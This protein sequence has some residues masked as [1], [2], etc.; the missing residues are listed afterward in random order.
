MNIM[1]KR[2]K[3]RMGSC[4]CSN[5]GVEF[6]KALSELKRNEKLGRKNFCS[7]S[8]T[9]YFNAEKLL[10]VKNRYDIRKHSN[11]CRDE[12]TGLRDFIRR[13]KKR[14]IDSDIDLI[15]LKELWDKQNT[16]IYTGVKLQLPKNKGINNQL[17][18][19]SLDRIDSSVGY[20]KGNVQ[21]VSIAANLAKSSLSHNEMIL[22]CNL[23][24]ENR[25][26]LTCGGKD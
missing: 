10:N 12:F 7:R 6:E 25:K 20:F 4:T 18:T 16:C 3:R 13:I 14:T 1:K 8:C 2:D 5:C 15:Y 24:Y 11:N 9:G 22:L 23:I 21:F 17:Y 19:A 26:I